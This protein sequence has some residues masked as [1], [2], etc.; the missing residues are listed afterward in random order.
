MLTRKQSW[1]R[2]KVK[3]DIIF[4]CFICGSNNIIESKKREI[5]KDKK[6]KWNNCVDVRY[7]PNKTEL[8]PLLL[9]YQNSD[10]IKF[11]LDYPDDVEKDS[12]NES[13]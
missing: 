7:I 6:V 11:E 1:R 13:T 8:Q 4:C 12:I 3:N 10:Y 2:Q 5:S 9:W